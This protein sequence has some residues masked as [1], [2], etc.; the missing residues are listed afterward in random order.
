MGAEVGADAP[1]AGHGLVGLPSKSAM[2]PVGICAEAAGRLLPDCAAS[3][4]CR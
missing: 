4:S 3:E 1:V 2:V